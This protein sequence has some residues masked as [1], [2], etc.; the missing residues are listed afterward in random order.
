[1]FRAGHPVEE[2]PTLAKGV[3]CKLPRL[4]VQFLLGL[5]L[6]VASLAGDLRQFCG[7]QAIRFKEYRDFMNMEEEVHKNQTALRKESRQVAK[8]R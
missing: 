2:L 6:P 8:V 4:L 7:A 5:D 1:M 3:P